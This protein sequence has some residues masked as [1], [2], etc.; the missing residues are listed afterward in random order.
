M[1]TNGLKRILKD[2]R[3]FTLMELI[4]VITI[5]AILVTLA[6]LYYG[7]LTDD[8]RRVALKADL[9]SVD[10]AVALYESRY[11]AEPFLE[12]I[13]VNVDAVATTNVPLSLSNVGHFAKVYTIDRSNMN[14]MAYVKRTTYLLKGL[15]TGD[16]R[17]AGKLYYVDSTTP[18]AASATPQSGTGTTITLPLADAQVDNFYNDCTINIVAGT[19]MGQSRTITAYTSA[20]KVATLNSALTTALDATS[21]Y[22]IY[23]PVKQGDIIFVQSAVTNTLMIKDNATDTIPIYKIK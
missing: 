13:P 19:G 9:Q 16:I 22:T 8:A 21:R 2:K 3:G 10:K 18:I 7:N 4:L 1:Q 20:T 5:L 23:P 12:A 6:L 11:N 17:G 15:E 14:F